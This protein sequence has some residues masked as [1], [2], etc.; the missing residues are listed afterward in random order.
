M[1]E[2]QKTTAQKQND[3]TQLE[4][5]FASHHG[6]ATPTQSA[7][8]VVKNR[9]TSAQETLLIAE[10]RDG[11]VILKD[12]SFKAV[13]KVAAVN[14]DLMSQEERESVEYSYQGFLNSL[15][16]P[17]Q[18]N[19]HS[20]RVDAETYIKKIQASL[21]RQN[22]MLLSVLVEDYLDFIEDL[23]DNTDIMNKNFFIV[24]PFYNNEF[25]KDAATTAGRNLLNRLLNFNK[26]SS[27]VAVDEKTLDTAR[28]E[29]RYRI[30]AIVE[31]LRACGVQSRPLGTQE[32]I[33][34]YYEFYNPETGLSQPLTNF[35]DMSTLF[36]SKAGDYQH[37][38]KDVKADETVQ[39]EAAA[40]AEEQATETAAPAPDEPADA[41]QATEQ[42]D[43]KG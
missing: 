42:T 3:W 25:S 13:V 24:I 33:E 2:Q 38:E 14:F 32:L 7:K 20:R 28:K 26:K 10:I 31:G 34:M 19:V 6:G 29:L 4:E 18:I 23:I 37:R 36:V 15:Y 22:N 30:Q 8:K 9:S 21:R 5:E 35:E 43:E 41:K 39:A 1:D 17:I 11:V 27:P 16:F 40:A 12:G